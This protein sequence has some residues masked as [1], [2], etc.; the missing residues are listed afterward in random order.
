MVNGNT[1]LYPRVPFRRAPSRHREHHP[2]RVAHDVKLPV[3][4]VVPLRAPLHHARVF[5][6]E[7]GV[8]R[9]RHG[10]AA[11][12]DGGRREIPGGTF[13]GFDCFL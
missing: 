2:A 4:A 7:N 1:Y 13:H 10:A 6:A 11:R 3:P 9:K 5:Q 12:R 8:N